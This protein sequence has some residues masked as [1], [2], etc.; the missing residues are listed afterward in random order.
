MVDD[1][2][3]NNIVNDLQKR[4]A[5]VGRLSAGIG[6]NIMT[7]LSLI[8]MNSD[9]LALKLRG[10]DNIQVSLNE[11]TNQ[12][13]IISKIAETM[14]WK[15]KIE[16]QDTPSL[17][18]VGALI[19]DNLEF[20]MGD[21]FFKHKLEKNFQINPQTPPIKAI[22]YFFTSFIDEWISSVIDRAKPNKT[23]K[24]FLRVDSLSDK[25]FFIQIEDSA[26]TKEH[27]VPLTINETD[28]VKRDYPALWRLINTYPA[29]LEIT[30]SPE[31]GIKLLI[32]WAL[33]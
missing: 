33:P 12:A 26:P 15:V 16:E 13:T 29:D 4:L 21:M 14:M 19:R 17:V 1:K 5:H 23:G 24:L 31:G 20:W 27:H 3:K 2:D 30:P 7:P 25:Q 11:I 10:T 18:Q 8:M 6:H 32:T 28:A 9:L 22:P